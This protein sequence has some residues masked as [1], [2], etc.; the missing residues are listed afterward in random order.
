MARRSQLIGVPRLRRKLARIEPES[1]VE[2][3]AVLN[4]TAERMLADMKCAVP[5]S[6]EP[7]PQ[8]HLRDAMRYRVAKSGLHALVGLL[9][10]RERRAFRY[11]R[12]RRIRHRDTCQRSRSP[13]R[14]C[15]RQSRCI[16]PTSGRP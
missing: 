11:W 10:P 12:Y 2:I 14:R 15:K 8:G 9:T 5:V 6:D 4:R 1:R 3:V 7:G 13:D 16:P